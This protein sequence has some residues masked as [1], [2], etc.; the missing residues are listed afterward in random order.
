MRLIYLYLSSLALTAPFFSPIIRASLAE[1]PPSLVTFE[2]QKKDYLWL[3]NCQRGPDQYCQAIRNSSDIPTMR[4]A[5]VMKKISDE[6]KLNDRVSVLECCVKIDEKKTCEA[7]S[8]SDRKDLDSCRK[9]IK[10]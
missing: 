4:D 2:N 9:A 7:L 8:E 6:K 5:V 3:F 1:P 10:N